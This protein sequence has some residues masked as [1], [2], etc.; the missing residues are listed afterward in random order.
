MICDPEALLLEVPQVIDS[1]AFSLVLEVGG[2]SIGNEV[3]SESGKI[4]GRVGSGC[5]RT[6]KSAINCTGIG[7]HGGLKVNM[8]LRPAAINSGIRFHRVDVRD[9]DNVIPALHDRVTDSILCTTVG[10]DAAS[11]T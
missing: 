11:R 6:L 9:R 8:T 2:K 5:Q 1:Q 4:V 7:L 3:M 10:N